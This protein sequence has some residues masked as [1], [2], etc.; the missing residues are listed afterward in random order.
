MHIVGVTNA[1]AFARKMMMTGEV[2]YYDFPNLKDPSAILGRFAG[3]INQ[4]AKRYNE[5]HNV[6]T[7]DVEVLRRDYL[8]VKAICQERLV[9]MLRKL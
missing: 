2:K 6:H 9:K 3:S 4:A 1:S 7:E 8:Q 5:T